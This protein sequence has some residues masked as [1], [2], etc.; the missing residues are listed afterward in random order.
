MGSSDFKQLVVGIQRKDASRWGQCA[1]PRLQE[2]HDLLGCA[3]EK[4]KT[5]GVANSQPHNNK[6]L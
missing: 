2:T 6:E 4:S 5:I 1:L 3:E